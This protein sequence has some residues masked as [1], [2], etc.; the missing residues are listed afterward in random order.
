MGLQCT[1]AFFGIFWPRTPLVCTFYVVNYTFFW[2]PTH[3]KCKVICERPLTTQEICSKFIKTQ[4]YVGFGH[5]C[6]CSNIESKMLSQL[7]QPFYYKT[8]RWKGK[9]KGVDETHLCLDQFNLH[10]LLTSNPCSPSNYAKS[11]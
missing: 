7:E 5:D 9:P 8:S 1:F 10:T 6:V 3:T 2:P 4:I 11:I